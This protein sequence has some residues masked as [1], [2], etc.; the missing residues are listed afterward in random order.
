MLKI[1]ENIDLVLLEN[2]GFKRVDDKI[3][4]VD[5][6]HGYQKEFKEDNGVITVLVHDK[7]STHP[8]REV[9]IDGGLFRSSYAHLNFGNCATFIFKLFNLGILENVED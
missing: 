2:Y 1:N 8:E 3:F 9:Y 6:V 5:M 7:N 4:F